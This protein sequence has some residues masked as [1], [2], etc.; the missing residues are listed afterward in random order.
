MTLADIYAAVQSEGGPAKSDLAD[1]IRQEALRSPVAFASF[2]RNVP[3]NDA[4]A[5]FE[6]YEVLLQDSKRFSEVLMSELTRLL[7]IAEA[8][9]HNASIFE[10]LT[11]FA[12][13]Q[14]DE[15]KRSM[16]VVLAESLR[17]SEPQ[18]RRFAAD[19][20]GDCMTRH[21]SGLASQL[22]SVLAHDA[23]WRVRLLA[24]SSLR[25]LQAQDPSSAR[26]LRLSVLDRVRNRLLGARVRE[27][28][29]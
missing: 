13:A 17:S 21:E 12:L 3:L 28:A 15:L 9:P 16:A 1:L 27:Y 23:D 7:K 11:A 25:D 22:R 26:D 4:C 19:L 14:D 5:L 18:I 10:Q 20:A 6:V 24:Y 8:D 29:A 2:L